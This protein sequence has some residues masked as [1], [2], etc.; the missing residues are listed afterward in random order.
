MEK[1]PKITASETLKTLMN[2]PLSPRQLAEKGLPVLRLRD[3]APSIDSSGAI[4]IRDAAA[5][6]HRRRVGAL[7]VRAPDGEPLAVMLSVDRYLE[8]VGKELVN[9]DQ[10]ELQSDGRI[11]P[12]DAAFAVSYVEAVN[13][14]DNWQRRL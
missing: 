6:L 1:Q 2:R 9:G 14:G 10:K 4:P 8:L 12:T 7:A 3:D 5:E 13:L 11:V